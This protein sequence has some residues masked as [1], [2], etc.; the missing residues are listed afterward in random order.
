ME[1]L[2][3]APA[4]Q[5]SSGSSS[6]FS[7][8]RNNAAL[9]ESEARGRAGA[10]PSPRAGVTASALSPMGEGVLQAVRDIQQYNIDEE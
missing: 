3:N 7:A 4:S 1:N 2:S 6:T 8:Q 10:S 5:A 9:G